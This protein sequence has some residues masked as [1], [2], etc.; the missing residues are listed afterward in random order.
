[1]LLEFV[2]PPPVGAPVVALMDVPQRGHAGT[3]CRV[4][5]VMKVQR[6]DVNALIA[7]SLEPASK[8]FH[9]FFVIGDCEFALMGSVQK[10]AERARKYMDGNSMLAILL[11]EGSVLGRPDLRRHPAASR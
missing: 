8:R 10:P 11:G 1:M 9:A 5:H 4:H 2:A 6:V 3:L 7:E